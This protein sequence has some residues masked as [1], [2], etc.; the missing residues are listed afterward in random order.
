MLVNMQLYQEVKGLYVQCRSCWFPLFVLV[1]I[2]LCSFSCSFSLVL[3]F[4]LFV[5]TVLVLVF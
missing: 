1:I 5:I 4:L 3:C 2:S